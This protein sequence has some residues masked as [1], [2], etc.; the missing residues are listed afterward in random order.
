MHDPLE[1]ALGVGADGNHVAAGAQG[2]D[3]LADDAGQLRRAEHRVESL[4][5]PFLRGSQALANGGQLAGGRV[6]NLARLIDAALNPLAQGRRIVELGMDLG[7]V[8]PLPARQP[9]RKEAGGAQRLTDVE[10]VGGREPTA[11]GR[12]LQRLSDVTCTPDTRLGLFIDQACRLV[13]L[14]LE[15]ADQHGIGHRQAVLRKLARRGEGGQAGELL[16]DRRKFESAQRARIR[17]DAGG[18]LRLESGVGHRR[19]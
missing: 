12:A 9:L 16:D 11:A 6:E 19:S 7:K 1:L 5:D 3:G 18:W 4:P 13:G 14:V 15:D 10:Q 2:D 8:L 17:G